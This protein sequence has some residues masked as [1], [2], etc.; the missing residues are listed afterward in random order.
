VSELRF[1]KV[2]VRY[3]TGRHAHVAADSVDLV[4]P[5]GQ[6]VG[7]VGESGSGKSTLARAAVGL[8][9]P[10]AGAILL[11][12]K[13]VPRHGRR[14]LQMVFQDP[15]AS[16]D[17][18]MTAGES[19]TEAI[20]RGVIAGRAARRSEAARLAELVG[21]PADTVDRLPGELS[22]GQRQRVALARAL[23]ARPEVIIADEITSALDVSTQGAVLNLVREL[24]RELRLSMLFISHNLAVVR[25]VADFVAVMYQGR[26]VEH[27]PA[28]AVLGSPRHAYTRK[29]LAAV[30]V[31]GSRIDGTGLADDGVLADDSGLADD[32][33]TGRR[34]APAV[35]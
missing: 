32:E 29:L 26:I 8:V 16:L 14:P 30:P 18:R 20:P 7:L 1:D 28:E 23:A 17:P 21:L 24:Q 33:D 25:Y 19:I 12:G 6:V 4:V 11:D 10:A 22:G 5:S 2:T 31:P 34:D 15:Y 35:T 13:P 27:G 9:A 3:G